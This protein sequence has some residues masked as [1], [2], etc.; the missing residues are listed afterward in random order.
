[1]AA[2]MDAVS[3]HL[4]W[5]F[6]EKFPPG[7]PEF[8]LLVTPVLAYWIVASAYDALDIWDLPFARRYK[9]V[10]KVPGRGNLVTKSQVVKRVIVQHIVQFL[11]AYG[12]YVVDSDQCS[13][14][15][16][17]YGWPGAVAM[18]LVGM[19]VM[20]T[21]QYWLH[22]YMHVN[23]F[24]YK[25]LHSHHHR[26]LNNYAYGALYNHPL[27]ALLLDSL[28]GVITIYCANMSCE[29]SMWFMTFATVKTVL[30]HC[31][32]VF[33]VNP[34]HDALPNGARFHDI[35]HDLPHIKKNFSQPFF[36]HWD[37]LMG[38]Y[39]TTIGFHYEVS[40]MGS[41]TGSRRA[42]EEVAANDSGMHASGS[43]SRKDQ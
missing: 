3:R 17:R 36:T 5:F 42:S 41:H 43:E 35:H 25:H 39:H 9:V 40:E 23:K 2:V 14:Q 28:G 4:H 16:N 34:L 22:R 20:D 21:Y 29:V 27:E 26:L 38:S 24:L 11:L 33:P 32:Y 8:G 30:D 37:W 31:G 18:W 13:R 7:S 15:A 19:L 12:M 10:R 1:M 6:V